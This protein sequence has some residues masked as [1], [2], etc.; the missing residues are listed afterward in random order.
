MLG[1]VSPE[2]VELQINMEEKNFDTLLHFVG[3][4]L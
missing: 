1:G 4:S 3:F 2:T